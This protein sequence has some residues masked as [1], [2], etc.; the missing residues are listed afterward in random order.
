MQTISKITRSIIIEAPFYG[1]Y[2]IG[3]NKKFTKE[4]QTA[5][6]AL[7]GINFDLEL[8]PDIWKTASDDYK[9]FLLL[10]E[11][12]H[13]LFFHIQDLP[14][15]SKSYPDHDLLNISMDLEVNSY[16][17]DKYLATSPESMANY[18]FATLP[19][20][21][22]GLGTKKYYQILSDLKGHFKNPGFSG[23]GDESQEV[24]KGFDSLPSDKQ[25]EVEASL[26]TSNDLHKEWEKM[27]RELEQN[28][29]DKLVKS[30]S[31][32]QMK[33]A[34]EQAK[35]AY[36]KG[37]WPSHL[38]EKINSLFK[39]K[40]PVF[41]WRSYFRRMLGVSFDIFQKKSRRKESK[42]FEDL[43]G[44]KFKKKHKILV[45]IDTS[46][47]VSAK[48][49]A[50]FFSELKHIYDAGADVHVVE[51][52]ADIQNEYDYKGKLPE[53]VHGRGGTSFLPVIDYYNKHRNTYN[54]L[55]YFTDGEGDQDKCH[56]LGKVLWI[57]TSDGYQDGTYPGIKI[58]I[59]K[60]EQD[61]RN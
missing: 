40:P 44:L 6:V 42:R 22:K 34:A 30:Q 15:W 59:P 31:E 12:G 37:T 11:L 55:V 51:C 20:L 13:L 35:Q 46:G 26:T 9:K 61:E 38:I 10:H 52:D 1:L 33:T 43:F 45:G 47:S 29:L 56:P 25:A 58:C 32:Y 49:F 18:L 19:N 41:N 17:Q 14:T 4:V 2:L 23:D 57:I 36:G 54:T 7:N 39:V 48:E 3:L 21:E 53:Q 60:T 28:G 24:I 50:D 8:N 16:I 5:A 27:K